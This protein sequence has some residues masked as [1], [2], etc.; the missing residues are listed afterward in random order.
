MNTDEMNTFGFLSN[1]N[2]QDDSDYCFKPKVRTEGNNKSL[3]F[4]LLF[5]S[6]ALIV[7]PFIIM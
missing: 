5:S 6:L 4:I 7:L 3:T 1:R 2:Q